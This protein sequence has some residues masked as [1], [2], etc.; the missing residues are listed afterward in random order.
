M[1]E[2]WLKA[3]CGTCAT[4]EE[5][6]TIRLMDRSLSADSRMPTVPLIAGW[7]RSFSKSVVLAEG[8]GEAMCAM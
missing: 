6:I 4:A 8:I 3:A 7:M 5:V 2:S 1:S